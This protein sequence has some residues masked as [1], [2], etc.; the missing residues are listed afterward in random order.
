[1]LE[2]QLATKQQVK[3]RSSKTNQHTYHPQYRKNPSYT[4][5]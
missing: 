5:R 4:D 2:L 3:P 1:M